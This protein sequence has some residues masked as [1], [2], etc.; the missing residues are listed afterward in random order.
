MRARIASWCRLELGSRLWANRK[1]SLGNVIAVFFEYSRSCVVTNGVSPSTMWGLDNE[2]ERPPR[3]E[4]GLTWRGLPFPLPPP[5]EGAAKAPCDSPLSGH[6]FRPSALFVFRE[7]TYAG[8]QPRYT[9]LPSYTVREAPPLT[10]KELRR[11]K[12]GLNTQAQTVS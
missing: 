4:V 11:L 5:L 9:A 2:A 10:H 6:V 12:P 1:A 8:Q 3:E 7:Q